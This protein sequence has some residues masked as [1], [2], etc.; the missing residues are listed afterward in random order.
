MKDNMEEFDSFFRRIALVTLIIL[1][2]TLP[3]VTIIK[4]IDYNNYTSLLYELGSDSEVVKNYK[5]ID[6]PMSIY[7][8]NCFLC[9]VSIFSQIIYFSVKAINNRKKN[10]TV[11]EKLARG[12]PILLLAFF[13]VW[14]SVGC[15]QA[16]MEMDAEI[17]VR[18]AK[19]S[20]K[21]PQ[22][23]IDIANWSSGY[24][25]ANTD[26]MYQNAR[27]RAWNGC[28]NLKDGYFSFLFYASVFLNILMLG[29]NA[30]GHKKAILRLLLISSMF[31]AIITYIQ[32]ISPYTFI[33]VVHFERGVFNNKNHFAYYIS[34][35]LIMSLVMSMTEKNWYFKGL[36]LLN[37]L[38]YI[39]IL[40]TNNTFG[41]YIGVACALLFIGVFSII[42]LIKNRK[43]SEFVFYCIGLT[44][45]IICSASI[46]GCSYNGYSRN[47][48]YFIIRTLDLNTFDKTYRYTYNTI[49]EAE[50]EEKGLTGTLANGSPVIWGNSV[51]VLENQS[52]PIVLNNVNGLIRDTGIL[53]NF[54]KKTKSGDDKVVE[55]KQY[56]T[57]IT[58]EDL[59]EKFAEIESKY[60]AVSGETLEEYTKRQNTINAEFRA[61]IME[62][63]LI[64]GSGNLIE[65]PTRAET[66]AN[67]TTINNKS[68]LDDVVSKTGSGRGEVW[69]RSLDLMNQRPLFGWGLENILQEFY[70]QY[71]IN[72]GRTH[73]LVLQLGATAG[74]PAVLMYLVATISMWFKGLFDAK[75]RKYDKNTNLFIILMFAVILGMFNIVMSKV[76]DKLLIIWLAMVGLCACL[77]CFVYIKK[78]EL[79][80]F[81][82]NEFEYISLAV[83]VSYMISSLF[84]NSAFYTS[85]YFMIFLGMLAYE[86]LNKNNQLA[87]ELVVDNGSVAKVKTV[88]ENDNIAKTTTK[89]AI[90]KTK[91][92]EL[93]LLKQAKTTTKDAIAKTVDSVPAQDT[94]TNP[95][96][97]ATPKK[98][99]T[100]KKKSKRK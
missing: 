68:G 81:K 40:I 50:A 80:A 42:R 26:D 91:L 11:K 71:D 35:V 83:F 67:D 21:V 57:D 94:N 43:I 63:K 59:N 74:I 88:K 58:I 98:K 85:P 12:W 60:V 36:A 22:R 53:F 77:Y 28:N 1:V 33:D 89:D 92:Q 44:F 19:A 79:R 82:W 16:A 17:I 61:Y 47:Y 30:K 31:M 41:S 93:E 27:D 8:I 76:T 64:D 2:F 4:K 9:T 37:T 97:K 84:G 72:E 95:I 6:L 29:N 75:L 87:T 55:K 48:V 56:A 25:M 24:R 99:N 5:Q 86:T 10:G 20:D 70:Q 46:A 49:D 34:V 32:F 13:M 39:L 69:I 7:E 51:M 66:T 100:N 15:I 38:L 90:A 18:S 3:I 14:T 54:F 23:I 96:I 62:N 65:L 52:N 45:F 73:N 78:I